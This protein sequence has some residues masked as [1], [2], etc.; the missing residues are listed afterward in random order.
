MYRLAWFLGEGFGIQAWNPA[1]SGPFTGANATDWMKPDLYVDLTSSLDRAGFDFVLVEDT[2]QIDDTF[3]G[4]AE[5]TLRVGLWAPKSDPLPLVPLMAQRSKHVGIAVTISTTFYHP[6]LAA[7]LLTT[8]DHLTEGRVGVNLVTSGSQQAAQNYGY[9]T[10]PPKDLRYRMANEWVSVLRRLQESWEPD[11]VRA[12]IDGGIYAD[13]T[14][15]HRL[16]FEG[17]FFRCRG[18]LNTIPGPQRT[19]PMVEAGNSPAGRDLAARFADSMIAQCMTIEDMKAFR[20]DMHERLAKFGREPD[21]LKV[22]YLCT[23]IVAATDAEAE[24][25]LDAYTKWRATDAGLEYML[26]YLDHVSGLDFGSF[27]LDMTVNDL[28]A[29]VA[30]LDQAVS[31][32][33]KVFKGQE[34]RTLRDVV[35]TR[36][37]VVNLGLVGSPT[38]VASKMDEMMQEVGGDGFL[39]YLPTTRHAI[40][41][42]CDGL[43]PVLKRR[44][45]IRDGYSHPTF[46]QNLRSF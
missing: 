39:F 28:I 20:A 21:E 41:E 4:S 36:E 1:M 30:T 44:G 15:V 29:R 7:R 43:A 9:K 27:D 38:T 25:R 32:L 2:S 13:H 22:M 8:L 24:A 23:P 37:H 18:P 17:E 40:A 14:K 10:L 3:R 19:V 5:T 33:A 31:S 26:W 45:S 46:K 42:I 11:A 35:A 34:G 16:D 12:D 6:Y